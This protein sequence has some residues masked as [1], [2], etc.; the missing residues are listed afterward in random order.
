MKKWGDRMLKVHEIFTSISGEVGII[1]QGGITTFIR[2]D[3]CNLDCGYC[4]TPKTKVGTNHI[5]MTPKEVEAIVRGQDVRNVLVT[6]GEPLLQDKDSLMELFCRLRRLTIQ[7]ETNGTICPDIELVLLVSSWVFDYKFDVDHHTFRYIQDTIPAKKRWVK[8]P[9]ESFEQFKAS[10][11]VWGWENL[12]FSAIGKEVTPEMLVRWI[13][14]E[15]N[16]LSHAVLNVQL[17]KKVGLT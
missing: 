17:H 8:V 12:A 4:D 10:R 5:P 6:G 14:G 7:V 11:P 1:P 16:F 9:V 15:G 3:G 2:M 13:R